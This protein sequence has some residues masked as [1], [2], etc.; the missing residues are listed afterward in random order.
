MN[1]TYLERRLSELFKKFEEGK[2][3]FNKELLEKDDGKKLI[4]ELS[5]LKRRPDGSIDISTATPIVRSFARMFYN[6]EKYTNIGDNKT[7]KIINDQEDSIK[8]D[9][10]II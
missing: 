3:F 1:S 6:V 8:I 5:L 2:I 9:E 4:E 7:E 10:I